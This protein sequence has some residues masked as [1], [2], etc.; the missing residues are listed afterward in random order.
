MEYEEI[1]TKVLSIFEEILGE[2]PEPV[3]NLRGDIGVDSL[4]KVE[5]IMSVEKQFNISV[6]DEK[7]DDIA[8]VKDI[9]DLVNKKING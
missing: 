8:T 1:K 2:T 9:I 7:F 6:E 5:I 4:D 3:S